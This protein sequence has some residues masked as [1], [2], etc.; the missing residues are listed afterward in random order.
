MKNVNPVT[1]DR[2]AQRVLFVS[3]TKTRDVP[4]I[5]PERNSIQARTQLM[6]YHRLLSGTIQSPSNP[7]CKVHH[8]D[9]DVFWLRVGVDPFEP[10]SDQFCE[11]TGLSSYDAILRIPDQQG[12]T[13]D[14]EGTKRTQFCLN[15]LVDVWKK[16]LHLLGITSV[17]PT[18]TLNYRQRTTSRRKKRRRT[19]DGKGRTI[20]SR[21]EKE[22]NQ[23]IIASLAQAEH[24]DPALACAIAESLRAAQAEGNLV[25]EQVS[26]RPANPPLKRDAESDPDQPDVN[27]DNHVEEE[28]GQGPELIGSTSFMMDD[29]VLDSRLEKVLEWWHGIRQP[30][31]VEL[32]DTGR[33]Q[34]VLPPPHCITPC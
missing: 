7:E 32:E 4:T 24:E 13:A 16:S 1:N 11:Q 12:A 34:Y 17:D 18:L 31:G 9:F 33:C 28:K 30:E 27:S 26:P 20:S 15:T 8:L 22:L 6:L 10:F 5:P 23:A 2:T 21:E 19:N 3:D 29:G 14:N 25:P